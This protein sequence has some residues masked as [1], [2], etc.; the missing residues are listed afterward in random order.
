MDM[1]KFNIKWKAPDG[2]LKQIL[3]DF[4]HSNF[5]EYVTLVCD[6]QRELKAHRIVL[7]S[8]S[9]VMKSIL[10]GHLE[11]NPRIYL[12]EIQYKYMESILN[13]IYLGETS[14]E[15]KDIQEITNI[16]K[17]LQ[18]KEFRFE[19]TEEGECEEVKVKGQ[20]CNSDKVGNLLDVRVEIKEDPTEN[21]SIFSAP[22]QYLPERKREHIPEKPILPELTEENIN[23]TIVSDKRKFYDTCF[24]CSECGIS[25][26][27]RKQLNNHGRTHKTGV[28]PHCRKVMLY[29][30][31]HKHIKSCQR[32]V[33]G[34]RFQCDQC[35]KYT[36]SSRGLTKHRIVCEALSEKN[37][38][39]HECNYCPYKSKNRYSRNRHMKKYCAER[40][41]QMQGPDIV[42]L[43]C[44]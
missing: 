13:F 41:K 12:T 27:T 3:K 19:N 6:D 39:M 4:R 8:L 15:K 32:K 30:N 9:D 44:I 38:T 21:E 16:A 29:E 23:E 24:Y 1:E 33:P 18:L 36:K 14:I 11:E 22:K 34:Q 17:H 42:S 5:L 2:L 20:A 26:T 35:E 7:S 10:N 43:L 25:K 28:C 40:K 37:V 31:K